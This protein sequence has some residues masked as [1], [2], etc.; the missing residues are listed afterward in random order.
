MGMIGLR[1]MT[2]V[3]KI[4]L[5]KEITHLIQILIMFSKITNLKTNLQYLSDQRPD[6][7]PNNHTPGQGQ[8]L[9]E[10]LNRILPGEFL[11]FKIKIN[12]EI[13][14]TKNSQLKN[15]SEHQIRTIIERNLSLILYI[16]RRAEEHKD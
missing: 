7:F 13:M 4:M 11:D 2:L 5:K 3:R 12:S 10:H 9:E 1:S 15:L 16:V 14:M 8:N 6:L